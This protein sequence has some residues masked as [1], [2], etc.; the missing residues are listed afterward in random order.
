[1]AAC[2]ATSLVCY[3]FG[4]R[5]ENVSGESLNCVYQHTPK[6]KRGINAI[7]ADFNGVEVLPKRQS[8]AAALE[9]M[10][11]Q[12]S[13][14][15]KPRGNPVAANVQKAANKS[16]QISRNIPVGNTTDNITKIIQDNPDKSNSLGLFMERNLSPEMMKALAVH[17]ASQAILQHNMGIMTASKLSASITGCSDQVIRRWTRE[18][19]LT[20]QEMDQDTL[21]DELIMEFM[22]SSRGHHPKIYSLYMCDEFQQEAR[23]FIREKACIKGKPNLTLRDF[24]DW[25]KSTWDHEICEETARIW[26]HKLGFQQ[27]RYG[28]GVYFDGHER[29]DVILDR[30]KYLQFMDLADQRCY[31]SLN[32]LRPGEK[33]ILRVYHDESTF[34]TNTQQ[35]FYW[36]DDTNITLRA[37]S[38]GQAIM[39]SDYI[40]E[41]EGFLR[42]DGIQARE[43]LEH[44]KEGYFPNEKFVEQALKAVDIFEAKYPGVIGMF[45]FDNAPSHRKVPEDTLNVKLMNVGS[46]GVQP[47]M[48]DTIWNGNKQEMN[49]PNG[50]PKGMW[51]ILEE[52]GFD[53]K[54]GQQIG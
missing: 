23:H 46:G 36:S 50:T 30:Q 17:I 35:T 37:K 14:P 33:P 49:F 16:Q 48:K 9:K 32:L 11:R 51:I 43:T 47:R 6:R 26:M 39:V 28:K 7:L 44:S 15:A 8:Q 4:R 27:K 52:R 42:I 10:Q 45:I 41:A 3:F 24:V 13:T 53:T 31:G 21:D 38:L 54:A 40:D 29:E 34:Y 5:M 18:Y 19:N 2:D 25:V 1:M 22:S 20:F 12:L